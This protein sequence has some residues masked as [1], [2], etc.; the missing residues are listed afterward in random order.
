MQ[1][2][3]TGYQV[4]E[5]NA[6]ALTLYVLINGKVIC[7]WTGYSDNLITEDTPLSTELS[8]DLIA[9]DAY[10]SARDWP[11]DWPGEDNPQAMYDAAL[12][13][14]QKVVIEVLMED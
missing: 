12:A 3:A 10:A 1:A 13:G 4:I 5:D 8:N 11:R 14:G 2:I 7:A 9:L 6:G